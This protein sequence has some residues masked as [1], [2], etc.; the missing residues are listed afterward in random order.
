L[1]IFHEERLGPDISSAFCCEREESAA[2]RLFLVSE[3]LTHKN[4]PAAS[5]PSAKPEGNSFT[6]LSRR[7]L[8]KYPG[9]GGWAARY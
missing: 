2:F 6:S 1:V 8:M 5:K 9:C 7:I 3:T 4:A